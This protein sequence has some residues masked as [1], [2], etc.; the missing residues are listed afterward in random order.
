ME[1][2]TLKLSQIIQSIKT[3]HYIEESEV[4]KIESTF[5]LLINSLSISNVGLNEE[6]VI[7]YTNHSLSI[8]QRMA[9]WRFDCNTVA[10]ALLYV[11]PVHDISTL[12]NFKFKIDNDTYAI[13]E[14]CVNIHNLITSTDTSN[15]SDAEQAQNYELSSHYE[16]LQ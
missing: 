6:N 9:L 16:P 1:L 12:T 13:L 5:D 11:L 14:G 4:Q 3:F 8:A 10:A 15:F 7:Y 2:Q